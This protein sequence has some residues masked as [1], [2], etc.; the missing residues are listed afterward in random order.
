MREKF[1]LDL[2]NLDRINLLIYGSYGCG[3]THLEGD[4]LRWAAGNGAVRFLNIKGEDGSSSLA[5]MGLGAVGETV[6]TIGEY[7]EAIAEYT[8][9]GLYGLGIDSLQALYDLIFFDLM[10]EVRLP[11]A[12]K[13]GERTRWY[14]GEAAVRI[15]DM[16]TRSRAAAPYVMWVA[17]HD[18][19]ED[20]IT[21]GKG[22]T[23]NLPG[24]VAWDIA[25]K[26]DFVGHMTADTLGADR[27]DRFVDFSASNS[28]Q[29]RQRIPRPLT[30]KIKIPQDTGGWLAIFE[31]MQKAMTK[32]EKSV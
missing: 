8:K 17:S 9:L 24:K 11:D 19:G 26:F 28:V 3:K 18:K 21:G 10:G 2:V 29:T 31:A 15:K 27:V 32:E 7:K 13:D 23:A 12:K 25:G 1:N 16:V 20:V 6:S 30:R 14:W 4:F 5:H 22:T